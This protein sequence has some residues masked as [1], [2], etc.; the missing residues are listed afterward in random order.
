MCDSVTPPW[1]LQM[2][3]S[4][5]S[6][7]STG[8]TGS[9]VRGRGHRELGHILAPERTN[10]NIFLE[11]RCLCVV[12][13]LFKAREGVHILTFFLFRGFGPVFEKKSF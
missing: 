5:G 13:A 8:L 6:E 2:I 11:L 3:D 7:F 10:S 1:R 9:G 4:S 12:V